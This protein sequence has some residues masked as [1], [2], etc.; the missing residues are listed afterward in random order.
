MTD[1]TMA[2]WAQAICAEL[3]EAGFDVTLTTAG[4]PLVAMPESI[5]DK[6][7]LLNLPSTLH[8][9]LWIF[10]GGVMFLPV[11]LRFADNVEM[12]DRLIQQMRERS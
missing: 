4:F 10:S 11:N 6:S 7:R 12:L 3:Q 2:Q 1:M 8:Y 5:Q 9:E